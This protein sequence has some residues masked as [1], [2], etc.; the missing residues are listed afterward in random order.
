MPAKTKFNTLHKKVKESRVSTT[1][2]SEF[3]L[4]NKKNTTNIKKQEN[5]SNGQKKKKKT[6]RPINASDF[7]ISS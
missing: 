3:L 7:A 2:D 6:N 1:H 4:H 5:V